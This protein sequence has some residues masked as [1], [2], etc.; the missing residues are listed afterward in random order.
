[1]TELIAKEKVVIGSAFAIPNLN[2]T[3][4]TNFLHTENVDFLDTLKEIVGI[5]PVTIRYWVIVGSYKDKTLAQSEADRINNRDPTLHAFVG[6]QK[7]NNEYYPVI[8]GR[9][10]ELEDATDLLV[11]AS[12]KLGLPNAYLSDFPDR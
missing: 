10:S 12:A 2:Y 11:K 8:V 5:Q 6:K 9:F 3:F 4:R 7:P 1:M